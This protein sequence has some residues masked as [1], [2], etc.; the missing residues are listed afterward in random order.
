MMND[1]GNLLST[2][3][4]IMFDKLGL[5]ITTKALLLPYVP[6]II[7]YFKNMNFSNFNM[8]FD[9]NYTYYIFIYILLLLSGLLMIYLYYLYV[10]NNT[11]TKSKVN[12]INDSSITCTITNSRTVMGILYYIQ[13]NFNNKQKFK[14]VSTNS[15][16]ICDNINSY[17]NNRNMGFSACEFNAES[18]YNNFDANS[19]IFSDNLSLIMLIDPKI[20]GVSQVNIQI[21]IY[22]KSSKKNAQ[23]EPD[24]DSTNAEKKLYILM[25]ISG[26]GKNQNGYNFMNYFMDEIRKFLCIKKKKTIQAISLVKQKV[27]P[28]GTNSGSGPANEYVYFR[29]KL[30][31]F[32]ERMKL[33]IDTFTHQK[34][35]LIK[36][37]VLSL[38]HHLENTNNIDPFTPILPQI[39]LLLYGPPGSGKS[40]LGIRLSKLY[41]RSI[42]YID[43]VNYFSINELIN[44]MI[45]YRNENNV[46]VLDEIDK[47]IEILNN[48]SVQS[49]RKY[50]YF[51]DD[52]LQVFDESYMIAGSI[53]IATTNNIEIIENIGKG[54]TKGAMTRAGRLLKMRIGYFDKKSVRTLLDYKFKNNS[55]VINDEWFDENNEM[56]IQNS[57]FMELL[58]HCDNENEINKIIDDEIISQNIFCEK[59]KIYNEKIKQNTKGITINNYSEELDECL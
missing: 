36:K 42:R 20:F 21:N 46:I 2:L 49:K 12:K 58:R 11:K 52:L 29:T 48:D 31:T 18:L 33:Y 51:A 54:E 34:C 8:N 14:S 4:H 30:K 7:A 9:M 43:L 24:T 15:I 38:N 40:T 47:F 28:T 39:S 22:E 44:D 17:A 41:N 27:T 35:P 45:N 25:N 55:I 53:T 5:S 19:L 26:L 13:H 6:N 32:D 23:D 3:T 59:M 50:N 16:Q 10:Y 57:N 56:L 1:L 37:M